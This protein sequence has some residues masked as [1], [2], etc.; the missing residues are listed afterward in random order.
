LLDRRKKLMK[1]S[2]HHVFVVDV[3][4]LLILYCSF[5]SFCAFVAVS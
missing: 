4:L 5:L 2:R 3:Y 1:K